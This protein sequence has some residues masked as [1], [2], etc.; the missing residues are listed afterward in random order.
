MQCAARE[1]A[2]GFVRR[3]RAVS[4]VRVAR[5]RRAAESH[6]HSRRVVTPTAWGPA[7]GEAT[8]FNCLCLALPCLALPCLALEEVSF[9]RITVFCIPKYRDE[10][11]HAASGRS[12]RRVRAALGSHC[13][14]P[15]Q[16]DRRKAG[17]PT[18]RRMTTTSHLLPKFRRRGNFLAAPKWSG[19]LMCL[20]RPTLCLKWVAHLKEF[21]RGCA[22]RM[23]TSSSLFSHESS[24]LLS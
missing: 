17:A 12:G 13:T 9:T 18:W 2:H 6:H 1:H 5:P 23:R 4:A 16:W 3:A 14:H 10:D 21:A 15:E 7:A 8:T 11:S 22:S 19:S 24:P 20:Y